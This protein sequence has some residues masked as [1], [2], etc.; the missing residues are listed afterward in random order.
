M[1]VCGRSAEA[2][3]AD[4]ITNSFV[5]VLFACLRSVYMCIM[6]NCVYMQ[7]MHFCKRATKAA[8]LLVDTHARGNIFSVTGSQM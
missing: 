4:G 3:T 8:L 7:S 5:C 6:Q 1:C 2:I